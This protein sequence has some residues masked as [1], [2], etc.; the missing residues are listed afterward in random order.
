MYANQVHRTRRNQ[1]WI[2]YTVLA[3]ERDLCTTTDGKRRQPPL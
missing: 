1:L 2:Q 3:H